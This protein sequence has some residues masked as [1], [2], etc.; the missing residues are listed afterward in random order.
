[1]ISF[2]DT[3]NAI[4]TAWTMILTRWLEIELF[5]GSWF[6][7][8][9]SMAAA[10]AALYLFIDR[11]RLRELFLYGSLLA[12]SFGY[13]DIV[14]I[15]TGLWGYKAH[16]L[17]LIT[18]LFPYAITLHPIIHMFAYQ[19]APNWRSFF[20]TN[21]IALAFFAFVAQPFY[22]W[23]QVFQP[24]KWNF[25]YSFILASVISFLARAIVIWFATIEQKHSTESSTAM[26]P[27]L[28]PAM[29]PFDKEK[30]DQG[31]E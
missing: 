14:G 3:V 21:T 19:Y 11:G 30:G 15:E 29:K 8:I 9:G 27:V 26:S 1:M 23:V 13:I 17:P 10:Y 20:V 24:L 2:Y 28:Q 12:V 6:A 16:F 7:I 5:S 4:A 31:I 25:F 18:S 22:V